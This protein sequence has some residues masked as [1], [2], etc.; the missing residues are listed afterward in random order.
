M[1]YLGRVF[2]NI[3]PNIRFIA[4]SYVLHYED[5]EGIILQPSH[6]PN[7][8]SPTTPHGSVLQPPGMER[9]QLVVYHSLLLLVFIV[10]FFT[11]FLLAIGIVKVH[12]HFIFCNWG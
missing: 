4:L 2:I 1:V 8:T 12:S 9:Q 3:F 10:V 5:G 11:C 7:Q 6:S